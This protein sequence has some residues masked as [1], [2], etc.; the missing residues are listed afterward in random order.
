MLRSWTRKLHQSNSHL[1]FSSLGPINV[2][3]PFC[4]MQFHPFL[5]VKI[6]GHKVRPNPSRHESTRSTER[7]THA[8]QQDVADQVRKRLE[9]FF[10]VKK[11]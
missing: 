4:I 2:F 10:E 7:Y 9:S 5:D 11:K 6:T 3:K 1:A 8:S